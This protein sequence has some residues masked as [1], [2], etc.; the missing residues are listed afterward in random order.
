MEHLYKSIVCEHCGELIRV[1]VYCGNRFCPLCSLSRNYRVQKK[2][3]YLLSRAVYPPGYF[4]GLIT[5]SLPN[6][7]SLGEGIGKLQKSFRRLRQSKLWK[8]SI[9]GGLYVI[10]ISGSPGSW[11]PHIHA[12]VEQKF[13]SWK[14]FKNRWQVISGGSAFHV[15][16]IPSGAAERYITKYISKPAT[17]DE[18]LIAV[19]A[20]LRHV[21]LFQPFGLWHGV[22]G[23]WAPLP[24]PCPKCGEVCYTLLDKLLNDDKQNRL[25]ERSPPGQ[26]EAYIRDQLKRNRLDAQP[27]FSGF[28]AL[29]GQPDHVRFSP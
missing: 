24:R 18:D 11:H 23:K 3:Q 14:T 21:R 15:K 12:L 22:L 16:K 28:K 7:L 17:R 19:A 5:V 2:I 4:L 6:C 29:S 9:R 26:S 27:E 1:P 10:E 25:V 8:K 20:A 13:I